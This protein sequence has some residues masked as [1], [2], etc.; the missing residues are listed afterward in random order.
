VALD[1]VTKPADGLTA[2]QRSFLAAYV[3]CAPIGLAATAAKVNRQSHHTWLRESE[4]YRRAFQ[5]AQEIGSLV[6]DALVTRAVFGTHELVL[7]QGEPAEVAGKLLYRTTFSD[8]L[9]ALLIRKLKPE[10]KDKVGIEHSSTIN[11]AERMIAARKR[12]IEMRSKET[13]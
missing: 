10:Y 3:R 2:K 4:P 7:H 11:I 9:L 1:A 12:L 13:A 6:E 8:A 5:E